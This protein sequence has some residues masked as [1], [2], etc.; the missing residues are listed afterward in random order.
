MG[1]LDRLRQFFQKEKLDEKQVDSKPQII[2]REEELKER[3]DF[4]LPVSSAEKEEV[5]VIA[6]SILAGDQP[7]SVIRI[8]EIKRI[9]IEK[10]IAAVIVAA[11]AA[12]AK[13]Q[14]TFVL[15]SITRIDN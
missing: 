12:E 4:S 6:S 9:D 15:R 2:E 11:I 3:I 8:K 14:S 7:N 13:P 1:I 10:E 5:A